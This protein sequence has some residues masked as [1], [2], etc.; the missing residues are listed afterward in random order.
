MTIPLEVVALGASPLLLRNSSATSLARVTMFRALVGAARSALPVTAR[1]PSMTMGP[2]PAAPGALFALQ[3]RHR[4]GGPKDR[5]PNKPGR[6]HAGKGNAV[7]WQPLL[8]ALAAEN[9][10][11]TGGQGANDAKRNQ[12]RR[13]QSVWDVAKRKEM[14]R[15]RRIFNTLDRDTMT[16][17][18]KSEYAKY[19][20]F[21]R[22]HPDGFVPSPSRR[23]Q[24]RMAAQVADEIPAPA[25]PATPAPEGT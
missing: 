5:W 13:Q 22:Q 16:D 18:I 12:I 15:R 3:V 1:L 6:P 19:A 24:K 11:A 14:A 21:L 23:Q 8:P 17:K 7:W 9:C 4:M 2:S 10:K 25:L 20:D